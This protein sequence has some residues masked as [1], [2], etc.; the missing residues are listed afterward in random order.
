MLDSI[1]MPHVFGVDSHIERQY[2][3]ARNNTY[4]AFPKFLFFLTICVVIDWSN[5]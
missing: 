2:L 5:V 1:F 4:G 3:A